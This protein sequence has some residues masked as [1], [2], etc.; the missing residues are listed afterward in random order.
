MSN[1][2]PSG[3]AKTNEIDPAMLEKAPVLDGEH[4]VDHDLGNV[5]VLHQSTFRALLRIKQRRN[6][7]GLEFVSRKVAGS[8]CDAG[9]LPALYA[10]R[11]RLRAVVGLGS[12]LDLDAI[13]QSTVAPHR[14]WAVIFSVARLAEL[15]GN[16][17]QIDLLAYSDGARYGINCRG[18][19]EYWPLE[20]LLNDPVIFDVIVRKPATEA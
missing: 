7:M 5:V 13:I 16:F 15:S 12:G 9:N 18:T 1:V 11:R 20:S 17:V 4:S 10:D 2:D 14:R 8:S 6:H 3:L 19:A